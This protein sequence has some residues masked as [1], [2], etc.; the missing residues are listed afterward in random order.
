MKR[1][2]YIAFVLL[3]IIH[4]AASAEPAKVYVLLWFDTEDYILP[5]SDDAAL[6]LADW[7]TNEGV[8][9]IVAVGKAENAALPRLESTPLGPTGDVPVQSSPV[10]TDA[11]QFRRTAIDLADFIR[12]QGRIPSSV[13][14]GSKP[15]PPEAF[16]APS[17]ESP[18]TFSTATLCPRESR[19]GRHHWQ[20]R[21]MSYPTIPSSGAG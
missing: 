5:A 8:R 7:L 14:L 20:R 16:S 11:S 18:G 17:P 9:A 21:N 19:S 10:T 3:F 2:L 1:L 6:R 15:V 4:P 12:K 13:W